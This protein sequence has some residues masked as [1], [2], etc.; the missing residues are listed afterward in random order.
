MESRFTEH[1]LRRRSLKTKLEQRDL[2][3][4]GW[5]SY[6][7]PAIAETFA[8]AGMDFVAID[9]EHTTIS[10]SEAAQIISA[11][12]T[13]NCLCLPRPV[14]HS[15]DIAKPL[16]EAAA[17]G[18]IFPVVE[19]PSQV[20]AI[21]DGFKFPPNGSRSYGV[22]RA[23][24]FGLNFDDYIM[25]WNETGS[26]IVQIESVKA[27]NEIDQILSVGGIDAVMIGPYDISGSLGVPGQLDHPDVK[28]ASDKVLKA[29]I[30]K[31][32]SCGTQL[33]N[34]NATTVA[35]ARDE[36]FN[37]IIMSSD[38]FVLSNWT[39]EMAGIIDTLR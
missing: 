1:Q 33:S 9:M 17:D 24:G 13:Q 20:K 26:L 7:E 15:G 4:A 31:G 19:T 6:R 28:E 38:L 5:V 11:T 25:S 18:L 23:H 35:R 27:V 16:L 12:H 34:A 3:F 30:K 14:S 29:C 8:M 32:I 39:K 36:G 2:V 21:L 22:N 37:L 10:T